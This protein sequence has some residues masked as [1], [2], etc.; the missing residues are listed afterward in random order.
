MIGSDHDVLTL[1]R[2]EDFFL[3]KTLRADGQIV[4]CGHPKHF[5]CLPYKVADLGALSKLLSNI[6]KAPRTAVIRGRPRGPG[7]KG[8][9]RNSDTFEDQP[10]HAIMLDVDGWT[11]PRGIDPVQDPEVCIDRFINDKLPPAF[12]GVSYHWQLSASA[13]T[14]K[15]QGKL[16]AHVWFWLATPYDSATLKAWAK[17]ES[18]PIDSAVFH[19]VQLHFTANPILE[20]GVV[21]SV[22]RRSGLRTHGEGRDAVPL[23][24]SVTAHRAAADRQTSIEASQVALDDPLAIELATAFLRGAA[25]AIEGAGGDS[26]TNLVANRVGDFGISEPMALDLMLEHWNDRCSPPW[27]PE[28]LREKVRSAYHSRQNRLGVAHPGHAFKG[29]AIEAPGETGAA[30]P[31]CIATMNKKFAVVRYGADVKVADISAGGRQVS[32]MEKRAF[33]DMYANVKVQD[34]KKQRNK[35]EVWFG[36]PARRQHIDPGVVFQ[37]GEDVGPGG[38]NLWRGMGVEAVQGDWS[39]MRDHALQIIC[40]ADEELFHWLLRYMAVCVRQLV[41]PVGVVVVLRGTQGCG[42][43]V[44]VQALGKLFGEHFLHLIDA[45]QL[46]GKFNADL[47]TALFVFLD[48]AVF[49][50]DHKQAAK[51]KGTITEPTLRIERKFCDA[52]TVPNRLRIVMATNEQW[53]APV[54]TSDRRYAVFDVSPARKGDGAYFQAL[55][56]QMDSGGREAM[57]FDLMAMDLAEFDVRAIP[58]TDARTEQKLMGLRGVESWLHEV[59]ATGGFKVGNGWVNWSEDGKGVCEIAKTAAHDAYVEHSKNQR[60]YRPL[61]MAQWAKDLLRIMSPVVKT[62]RP[63]GS[64]RHFAFRP[65][66]ICREHFARQINSPGMSWEEGE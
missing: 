50:A 28:D 39:L 12:Q 21:D 52:I 46:T 27:E 24:I 45:E 4:P 48:E 43:G 22:P 15:A 32:F 26:H 18:L 9:L 13:G 37:P 40:G 16:K 59:L 65:L 3:A 8:V 17:A 14:D 66:T 1:L 62:Y 19:P 42:K 11:P 41:R 38:L 49:A 60:E 56:D 54:E 20:A 53:A 10:L 36:H 7:R 2:T 29:I 44:F 30:V 47:G 51:L 61:P 6:E 57:L 33:F 58:Q 34:G 55:A 5:D 31:D 25:P 23:V 63:N 64:A 35:A